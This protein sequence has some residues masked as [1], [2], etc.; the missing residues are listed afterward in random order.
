M[1]IETFIA[2][3]VA[4]SSKACFTFE[5]E[6]SVDCPAAPG[7]PIHLYVHIPFCVQLCPYCSFHRFPFD[8]HAAR[9]YFT[10]LRRELAIYADQGFRFSSVYVGG[11]TPTVMMDELIQTID[12]MGR[13]FSPSEISVETNPDRLDRQSLTALAASG[14]RR[15]SVGVQSF[16]DEILRA[17][18]R[19]EKYGSGSELARRISDVLGV[20]ETLNV[21]MIYNFPLQDRSMLEKDLATLCE[22]LPEQITFYPLM[23]SRAT[24]KRM[25]GIMGKVSYAKERRFYSLIMDTL[26]SRYT[27][28]SAWCFSRGGTPMI[29]EY[30]VGGD[31]Y[32]GAGSGA[33]GLVNGAIHAN[34]FSL[35][36]YI[37]SLGMGILPIRHRKVFSARE[38]ARYSFLMN[39]F[40]L[41][42]DIRAFRARFGRPIWGV[43]GP[44]LLFFSLIGALKISGSRLRLT[45]RGQYYW[46]VM[47]REFFTGVDN[48]RDQSREAVG[49]SGD[50]HGSACG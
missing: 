15:V 36:E 26:D 30:V 20:V 2:W 12:H 27:P 45:R 43:L 32:V 35:P 8:E 6:S 29:D 47:M 28:N 13:L 39:L 49:I 10:A 46:V 18:G 42:L 33:F 19:F 40:G 5:E 14:V 1:G 44:D 34:T 25:E 22:I 37:H 23:I 21:D 38:M 9:A 41:T 50:P 48:F 4:R 7:R 11:G 24:R 31:D 3:F 17:I 16:S